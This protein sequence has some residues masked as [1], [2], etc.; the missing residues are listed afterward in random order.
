MT[1]RLIVLFFILF[2]SQH[3]FAQIGINTKSPVS[4][5]HIDGKGDNISLITQEQAS[6]DFVVTPEGN[7]GIGTIAPAYKLSV[8][9]DMH[10]ETVKDIMSSDTNYSPQT[11]MRNN[12]T[13]EV[14]I[15]QSSSGNTFPINYITYTITSRSGDWIDWFDTKINATEYIVAIVG[16]SFQGSNGSPL[17][18]QSAAGG[19]F[20][21][22]TVKAYISGSTWRLK[23]D[24]ISA[25]P[26]NNTNGTWIINCIVINSL[27]SKNLGNITQSLNG[28][29]TGE[30]ITV[31]TGL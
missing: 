4:L 1:Y 13:G 25:S 10:I 31:P 9:G 12:S 19:T 30:A 8:N 15:V 16:Y 20:V 28:T 7:V 26:V 18:L 11:M 17:G 29:N 3:I 23:A 14:V 5:F 6:N 21:P 2:L 27:L 24:Y 22:A